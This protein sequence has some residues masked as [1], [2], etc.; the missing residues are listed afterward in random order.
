MSMYCRA[1]AIYIY[2]MLRDCY[3]HDMQ[4]VYIIL[5]LEDV[6]RS[7]HI[8]LGGPCPL[9]SPLTNGCV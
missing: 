7:I 6:V 2:D 1:F 8:M 9:A 4:R 5:C 3:D